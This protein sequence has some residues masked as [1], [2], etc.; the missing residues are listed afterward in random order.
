M[1][2]KAEGK[3]T[4]DGVLDFMNKKQ[5]REEMLAKRNALSV[6]EQYLIS[7]QI[8]M[9]I[10]NSPLYDNF[11]YI[12]TYQAFRGEV[13]CDKV[14]MQAFSDGKQVYVPVTDRNRKCITFYQIDEYTSYTQGAYGIMEPVIGKDSRTLS[15]PALILMPG[16]AFDR[17]KHRIGYG[18]GYYDRYLAEHM[19]HKTAAL[20]FEFQVLKEDLPYEEHDILPDYIVTEKGIF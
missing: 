10:I 19:E 5:I 6:Q 11:Q 4:L 15:A 13:F 7:E 14:K 20:C 12:C 1:I 16:L 9:Q 18:G 2:E 8:S 17:K 3:P